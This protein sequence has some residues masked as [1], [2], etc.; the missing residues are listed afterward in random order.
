[1]EEDEEFRQTA[2]YRSLKDEITAALTL[3]ERA[4]EWPD[5]IT[6]LQRLSRVLISFSFVLSVRD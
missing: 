3:F 4:T 1:M 6:C 5:L 2:L